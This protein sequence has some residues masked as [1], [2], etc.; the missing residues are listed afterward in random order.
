MADKIVVNNGVKQYEVVDT[1][2]NSLGIFTFNPA[3]TNIV[4]RYGEIKKYLE[5]ME[6]K[7]YDEDLETIFKIED[8][9][10]EK[11]DYLFGADV[12]G[13]FFATTGPL[14]VI[15][16]GEPFVWSVINSLEQ[17]IEAEMNVRIEKI[18]QMDEQIK[19]HTD[20]YDG[21]QKAEVLT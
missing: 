19:K 14:A 2:G 9:I 4:R 5:E 10:K 13:T 1:F 17:V 3:D 6:Q 15:E 21:D 8:E 11:I 7:D 20:K 12:S 16:T 18:K